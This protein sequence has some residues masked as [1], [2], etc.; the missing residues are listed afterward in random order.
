[1]KPRVPVTSKAGRRN[2]VVRNEMS[3]TADLSITYTLSEP[4][5]RRLPSGLEAWKSRNVGSCYKR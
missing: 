1:M 4:R 2:R 3:S 5:L